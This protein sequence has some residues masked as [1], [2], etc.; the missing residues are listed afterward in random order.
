MGQQQESAACG[1]DDLSCR[2]EMAGNF[3]SY[4]MHHAAMLY[5]DEGT[6]G[7]YTHGNVVLQPLLTDP[8]GWWWSWAAAWASTERNILIAENFA[9]GVNRSDKAAGNNIIIENNTL[10]PWG[11]SWPPAAAAIIAQAGPR[12]QA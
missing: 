7:Y 4:A 6:V 1:A 5:H 3:V 2:S 12:P 8:H 11:S 10:L 9:V